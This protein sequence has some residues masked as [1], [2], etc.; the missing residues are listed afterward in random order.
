[1]GDGRGSMGD[2]DDHRLSTVAHRQLPFFLVL[3]LRRPR[4]LLAGVAARFAES[5]ELRDCLERSAAFVNRFSYFRRRAAQPLH[6]MDDSADSNSFLPC[7]V[8]N[9]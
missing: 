9:K 5:S 2:G 3:R 6:V 4:C 8:M 7:L 1:M